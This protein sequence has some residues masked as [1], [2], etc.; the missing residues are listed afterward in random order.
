MRN[1]KRVLSLTLASVMLLGMMVIGSSAAA[2]GY[3][4]VDETHN[5]EAIEVLQA[6]GVMVGDGDGNLRPDADVSRGEM[7]VIMAKLMD[8]DFQYYSAAGIHPFNDMVGHYAEAYV[9]ACKANGIIAGRT[10]TVYDPNAGV[11]AIEAAS[12]MM[13]ALGYF[14]YSSDY[15][16]GFEVAT[17]TQ[18]TR[19]GIFDD[20]GSDATTP[21]TRNQ[22]AQLAL[23][24]LTSGMVEPSSTVS[25]TT[26]DGTVV[27]AGNT[28]YHYIS[29]ANTY[30]NAIYGKTA[31]DYGQSYQN[32]FVL[33]L[34][35][36]LYK[37]DL[38]LNPT[39]NR[40]AFGRPVHQWYYKDTEVGLY[41]KD[42][43]A[44]Y[45]TSVKKSEL[46]N[47]VGSLAY[48]DYDL[49][50]Y[51]NGRDVQPTGKI[52]GS[53][54]YIG[55]RSNISGNA[56]GTN[57][58]VLTEVYKNDETRELTI[59]EVTTYVA[60]VLTDYDE[61]RDAVNIEVLLT[62][63]GVEPHSDSDPGSIY[64][65]NGYSVTNI[66]SNPN[67]D[68]VL[69][70]EDFDLVADLKEGDYITFT[71]SVGSVGTN[72]AG[73]DQIE[74]ICLAELVTGPVTSI[75][76]ADTSTTDDP[77]NDGKL[78]EVV[79]DETPYSYNANYS[80]RGEDT[81]YYELGTN[82]TVVL[83]PYGYIIWDAEAIAG[84]NN[85]VYIDGMVRASGRSS[86]AIADAYFADG[87]TG[88]IEVSEIIVR[89][90]P[91]IGDSNTGI[92]GS[93]ENHPVDGAN[94]DHDFN[95]N[96]AG[97]DEKGKITIK[98]LASGGANAGDGSG[99]EDTYYAIP[100]GY[101]A[102]DPDNVQFDG[103]YS[104]TEKA[105]G[106]YKLTQL[107]RDTNDPADQNTNFSNYAY[108]AHSNQV[109]YA[110]LDGK[111]DGS[112]G[113]KSVDSVT[114]E[115][116]TARWWMPLL[117]GADI[118]NTITDSYINSSFSA[119]DDTVFILVKDGKTY[120]YEGVKNL[121]EITLN[122]VDTAAA[123]AGA[124]K[125]SKTGDAIVTAAKKGDAGVASVVLIMD[126]DMRISGKKSNDLLYVINLAKTTK[127]KGVN[128]EENVYTYNVIL[129]GVKTTIDS[130]SYIDGIGI[131]GGD[132][133]Q[134]YTSW[135]IM[136]GYYEIDDND[137]IDTELGTNEY[138]AEVGADTAGGPGSGE[139]TYKEGRLWIGGETYYID[140]DTK[141]SV[142]L[143]KNK[144][145]G[146]SPANNMLGTASENTMYS[147]TPS[148]LASRASIN[149][150]TSVKY[151]F[152]GILE[153]DF[154]KSDT[155]KVL[156]VIISSAT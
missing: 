3:D 29:S 16:A 24:T 46:F 25:V 144:G 124:A 36:Q 31:T 67:F 137:L 112:N 154:G 132:V 145:A 34:G 108:S 11:T 122:P 53:T 47:L 78:K 20:V 153:N 130:K 107:W 86:T 54:T 55:D 136:D 43:I 60:K 26:T 102:D 5:V 61:D 66:I 82:A 48:R 65:N 7:A 62:D 37:G 76:D 73:Y 28:A 69:Y 52:N 156:Y 79:I 114:I 77:A 57:T 105:D 100:V 33:E 119:N 72:P 135:S 155:L 56:A 23:N 9:A 142:L 58:G 42:L 91:F 74:E 98:N 104:Y 103:W 44:T 101:E 17:V 18:G 80:D 92:L 121:P 2:Q 38:Q 95:V 115:A 97:I 70:G 90:T 89:Y 40:D 88:A 93:G 81:D 140:K 68:N 50:V 45:T 87:T 19:I 51:A 149:I 123:N 27:T 4:D 128:G 85:F 110:R 146:G 22:V 8:L 63:N 118:T 151:D 15:A 1:L 64:H 126:D 71:Y 127:I 125:T 14:K 106:T 143:T 111:D 12:M 35:E 39:R 150:Y 139:I 41:A 120:V 30:A 117:N 129:N 109:I 147:W 96:A 94:K 6:V 84:S 148:M 99:G 75:T 13:R 21:M 133:Y 32:G 131:G 138:V 59:V 83:D 116:G 113:G 134:A 49:T 141:I 152:Y 10:D